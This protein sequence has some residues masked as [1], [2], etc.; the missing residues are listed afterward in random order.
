MR[1]GAHIEGEDDGATRACGFRTREADAALSFEF[2]SKTTRSSSRYL[3]YD[4][5]SVQTNILRRNISVMTPR[6]AGVDA[7][8]Q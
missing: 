2:I 5:R 6:P 1:L 4:T 8:K 7:S 3:V